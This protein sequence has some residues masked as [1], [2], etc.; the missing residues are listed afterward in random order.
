MNSY[1]TYFMHN[2]A[3]ALSMILPQDFRGVC[4]FGWGVWGVQGQPNPE[5]QTEVQEARDE[6]RGGEAVKE[7]Q[8]ESTVKARPCGKQQLFQSTAV[9]LEDTQT[10]EQGQDRGV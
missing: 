6:W 3:R 9:K 8:G 1:N 2:L 4:G 5:K 7:G 10:R